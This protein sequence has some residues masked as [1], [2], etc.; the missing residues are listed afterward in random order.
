[1]KKEKFSVDGMTCA[2]CQSN[3][4]KSVKKLSGVVAADVNLL[5]GNMT[6]EYD[7]AVVSPQNIIDAV[8]SVG[9]RAYLFTLENAET[10]E[11]KN[12]WSVRKNKASEA[13]N[14]LKQRLIWSVV[15]LAFLMYVSMGHMMGLPLPGFF[16]GNN[17]P[18]AALTQLLLTI[19]VLFI[20]RKFFITGI[21]GFVKRAPNMDTLVSLGSA[22]SFIFS[23]VSLYLMLLSVLS[24]NINA[25]REYYHNLYFESSAM[26]LTL[27]TVGKFLETRSKSRTTEALQ[28]L[29]DLAPKT[30]T[31]LKDGKE[32]TVSADSIK[33]GDI[34]VIHPGDTI[35][36]DGVIVEGRGFVDASAVTGES[37]PQELSVD[38]SVICA[39]R[40][41]NGYF[42]F[43]AQKVGEDTTFAKIIKLVDDAGNSKAPIARIADVVS[44]IFVPIVIIIAVITAIVWLALGKGVETALIHAVSVLVISCPCA[45]GLAT[46]VAIMVGTGKAANLGVLIHS[47]ECLETLH[48]VNTVVFDKTGT[49]TTGKPTVKDIIMFSEIP[50]NEFIK[51]AASLESASTHPF[52]EAICDEYKKYDD[53]LLPI[54]DFENIS[55][56]G[57][58]GKIQ[59]DTWVAGN[60]AFINEEGIKITEDVQQVISEHSA[61]GNT[62]LLFANKNT[63][64]AAAAISDI[65]RDTSKEV[66]Y[67]LNKMNINTVMLTGDSWAV[68]ENIKT[69]LNIDDVRAEVMPADKEE[70]V[71]N[72]QNSGRTVAMIGDGINDA[73]ALAR[74]DVGIA[75]GAGTDV[76]IETA[77]V[78]LINNSLLDAVNAI[79]LSREVIKNIRLNLFWAFFYNVI[80]IPVAAGAF[81]WIGL[82]LSPMLAAAAM[83]LSSLFVVT[84][85]LRLKKFE[86][87][88]ES[89]NKEISEGKTMKKVLKIEGMMCPHCTGRVEQALLATDGVDSV[90]MSLEEGTATVESDLDNSLLTE[91]VEKAGY[92][93]ISC[94]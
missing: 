85:A 62:V 27:V 61:K 25:A 23:L 87:I 91:V 80:G 63:V 64:I 33:S 31:L 69:Q 50:V 92:K 24:G 21:N 44:G 78:V 65:I 53:I 29:I 66:I 59:G 52:A 88:V 36:A 86:G 81:S 1:M 71:R 18:L 58:K 38:S 39:T 84:N 28:K 79:K 4:Q 20:N 13:Q 3:V 34:I 93:V 26:I 41:I 54:T 43:K 6:V 89:K 5:A 74:A 75:I 2:A 83:S 46:P 77:D 12:M 90:V 10:S 22:V 72:L 68:A 42:K 9:Y 94:K 32:I 49:L 48:K 15:I 82:N 16:S 8:S 11:F 76:A 7:D 70:Y 19:P 17:F 40:N 45:L 14:A 60:L 51:T 67:R 73:P 57:I 35:P 55:G 37:I 47:A 56:R 30:A